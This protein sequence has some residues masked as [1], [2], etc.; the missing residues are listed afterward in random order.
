MTTAVQSL[1]EAFES[2]SETERQEA[3][4]EILRRVIPEGE[5]PERALVET[6]DELFRMLDAEEAVDGRS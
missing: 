6:A 2:L 4:V 5:L 1:L 3:A